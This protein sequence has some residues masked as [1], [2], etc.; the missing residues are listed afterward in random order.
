MK[1]FLIKRYDTIIQWWNTHF[2][3]YFTHQ[4][5]HYVPQEQVSLSSPYTWKPTTSSSSPS[6]W[7]PGQMTVFWL[8]GVGIVY[9]AY[10]AFQSLHIL[11]LIIAALLIS[12]AMESFIL[13][14]RQRV[15]RWVAIAI[16]YLLLFLFVLTWVVIILPFVLQQLSSI[17]T[18]VIQYFYTMG[19]QISTLWL[20]WYVQSVT[21]L[22]NIIQN[23]IINFLTA[24]TM[25]IQSSLMNNISTVVA[26][27]SDYAKNIW[28]FAI[29]FVGSFFSVLGQLW[30]VLTI[31]VLCSLEKD[32]ILDFFIIHTSST[33]E[34]V[35]YMAQKVDIFYRKMGLWLKSQLWLCLYI[36]IIVYVVL[37]VLS[38]F[39]ISLP[40]IWSLA[41]MAWFTEFIPY[42][43]PILWAIPAVIVATSLYGWK[44]LIVVSMAYMI[45]QWIENNVLIP[46]LMNKSL[47]VSSLLIFLC[48]L[49]GGSV[50]GFIGVLLAVP[51]AVVI[52]M[53]VKKDFK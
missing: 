46:V 3:W 27:G 52:T 13:F 21:W 30:L 39:G 35:H 6:G 4:N 11:Y 47:G 51:F 34:R 38:L 48:A 2:S 31:A 53:V 25:N 5:S 41:L 16:S 50:L 36:A 14:F 23:Y 1:W 32:R 42:L 24:D 9:A 22:P 37:L 40:N 43:W 33:Q 18:I 44:G 8:I 49:I 45:V 28:W 10:L 7:T 26:T 15:P 19:Q 17:M 29:S 20:L 12:V